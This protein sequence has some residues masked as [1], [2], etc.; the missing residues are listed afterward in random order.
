M[1][2]LAAGILLYRIRSG[3]VQ[4][5]LIHPGGPYYKRKDEGIWSVPKGLLSEGEE[6]LTA[7]VR[8]FEEETGM[9][10]TGPFHL[11]PQVKYGSGKR[12]TVYACEGDFEVGQLRSNTFELEWPPG[13]GV[14]QEF[15]E[16]DKAE[17][18]ELP[19]AC[20]KML[21]AQLILLDALKSKISA[22]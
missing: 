16:A 18:F 6:E 14:K 4:V 10:P 20:V 7:A 5:L 17:W 3:V 22:D 9:K 13:S 1:P 12:L 11:L 19:E 8:E 2:V 15:P 21:P